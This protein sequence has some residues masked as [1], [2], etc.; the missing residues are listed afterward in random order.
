[1]LGEIIMDQYLPISTKLYA[2]PIPQFM[3]SQGNTLAFGV[4]FWVL[5]IMLSFTLIVL[6][7]KL[8]LGASFYNLSSKI[9]IT[10]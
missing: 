3:T 5:N 9:P 4:L 6:I 1:M 8:V 10:R 7:H 2:Q